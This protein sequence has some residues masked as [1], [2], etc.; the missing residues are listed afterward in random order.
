MIVD[1]VS[2]F[3]LL[4]LRRTLSLVKRWA[5]YHKTVIGYSDAKSESVTS[6][7]KSDDGP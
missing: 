4:S 2:F 6:E 5:N 7:K 3:K 1:I